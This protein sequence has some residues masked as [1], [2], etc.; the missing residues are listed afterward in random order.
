MLDKV[1]RTIEEYHM[2]EPGGRVVCALSGGADSTAL[3]RALLELGYNVRAY[4]LNHCLRGAEADRDETFCRELCK[5]LGVPF[6]A[7]RVDVLGEAERAG[8]SVETIARR[9]RYER[10]A[11]LAGKDAVATAH[12]ADDNVETVLFNLARGT[13]A[14]GLAGIPPVRGNIVRPLINVERSELEIYL[15][16]LGQGF[17]TDSTN[18]SLEYTRNRI[19]HGATPVLRDINPGLAGA[20]GRLCAQL[21]CDD[22]CLT[23]LA[24]RIISEAERSGGGF[25]VAP[26]CEAHPAVRTRALRMLAGKA[27][28]PMRDFSAVHVEAL[29]RWLE[30]DD[31][32]AECTLPH[33]YIARR[34]YGAGRISKISETTGKAPVCLAVPCNTVIWDGRAR[35][36]IGYPEK[37]KVFNKSFNTFRV[38][39]GTID[40]ETLCVRTRRTGDSIRLSP[41]G[42]CRTL[43][44]LMIDLKIPRLKRGDLMVIADKKGVIAVESIGVD[45][46]RLNGEGKQLEIRLERTGA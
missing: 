37:N 40:F 12:T 41:N 44:K 4:H 9:L 21:R 20:V 16:S 14:R 3:L 39:C 22:E 18:A 26:L 46:A 23:T 36:I 45:A 7:D 30:S 11:A 27:G 25:N 43:K 10:L 34:E 31:P 6:T 29:E 17:V 1:R 24:R 38:D 19:R 15:A 2:L 33:G 28:M 8:E 35:V 5:G 13:G 32:S 42:Y